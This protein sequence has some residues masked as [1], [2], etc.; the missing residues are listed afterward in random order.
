M[1]GF[2]FWKAVTSAASSCC[3]SG[4]EP[5]SRPTTL[6]VTL[7]LG[8]RLVEEP[9]LL[10]PEEHATSVPLSASTPTM[11]DAS[12]VR[13]YFIVAPCEGGS[14]GAF[15]CGRW[16]PVGGGWPSEPEPD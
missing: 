1:F 9:L 3:A 8:S 4:F 13:E 16:F 12:V 15:P 5:G 14:S 11:A 7:V 6:S 2:S 10:S